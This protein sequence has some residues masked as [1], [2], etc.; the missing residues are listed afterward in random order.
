MKKWLII[1]L[2]MLVIIAV[3]VYLIFSGNAQD[4]SNLQTSADDFTAIDRAVNYLD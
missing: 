3:I 1:A 2:I 4:Y